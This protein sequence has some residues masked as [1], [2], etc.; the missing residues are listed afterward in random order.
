ME[1]PRH[2]RLK[3]QRYSLI[4]LI[5]P[6]T[7]AVEFPPKSSFKET[8]GVI[9]SSSKLPSCTL[10]NCTVEQEMQLQTQEQ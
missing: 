7:G 6:K 1:I 9:Y 10:D 3:E 5:N 4:G 2:W 8:S